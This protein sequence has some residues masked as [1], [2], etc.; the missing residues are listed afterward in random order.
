[1]K[2]KQLREQSVDELN[3]GSRELKHESLT[4]RI[5][6]ST[7]QLENPAR[8]KQIRREVARIETIKTERARKAVAKA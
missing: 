2:I 4:L 8:I 7:G 1:M 6:Q 5:Q 3:R